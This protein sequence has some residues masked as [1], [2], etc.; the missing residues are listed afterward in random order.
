MWRGSGEHGAGRGNVWATRDGRD[1]PP[2]LIPLVL[3]H[4]T[5]GKDIPPLVKPSLVLALFSVHPPSPSSIP[6]PKCL[7]HFLVLSSS[8]FPSSRLRPP[9]CPYE[10]NRIWVCGKGGLRL[11][12]WRSTSKQSGERRAGVC[13]ELNVNVKAESRPREDDVTET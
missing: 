7:S 6:P 1:R 10:H 11:S 13:E 12:P 8:F 3:L 2:L 5:S 9:S 4:D